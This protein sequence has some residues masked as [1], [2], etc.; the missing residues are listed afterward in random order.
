MCG[1]VGFTTRPGCPAPEREARYGARLRSMTASLRHRGPDAQ[2]AVLLDGAALGHARL[3]IV[4]LAVGAQPMIDPR[5][6]VTLIFNGEIFNYVEPRAELAPG[7]AFRTTSDT[8][9]VL[10]SYVSRGI[11]CVNDFIGQFAFAIF[12][13]RTR[14]LWLARDRVGI[15]PLH[16]TMTS[17]G[18]AFA[19]EAKAI[20]AGGWRE[21]AIDAVAL[22]QTLQLWSP[23]VP[24]TMFEGI[25][26]LAPGSVARFADGRLET[27]RYWDLDLGVEPRADLSEDEAEAELGELLESA[28]R[29]RLRADVP[30]AAY[31]SGGLDSSLL[32]AI[33]Q[34][35]LG[36]TLSTYSVAFADRSFDERGYQQEV[37]RALATDH[38][39]VQIT[40]RAIGELLPD[41]VFHAEQVLVRSAPAPLYALSGL[42]N[43]HRT[44]VVLTGEGSDEIFWGYDLFGEARVRQ[45]WSRQPKSARRPTLLRRL[46]PYLPLSE[47]GDRMLMAHSVEGRFP[48]LD[49]RLIE[50]AATLPEGLKL[51]GLKEKWILKRYA[52]RWVPER[53]LRRRKFPYRAPI[54]SA[55]TGRQAPR[56]ANALMSRDAIRER[57]IFD[58]DKIARLVAKLSAQSSS[59]SET[60]SQ[61]IM[62]VATTQLLAEQFL[63]PAAVAQADI[64]AVD[65]AAA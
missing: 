59:P 60:D 42:V 64:D 28:V 47:Q 15:L 50:F 53:V 2:R 21:P 32:S 9:V 33:A 51:R 35:Q 45:F 49:H 29:L 13:P 34:S 8:E 6:G 16:Y 26:Q 54:A 52:A 4:D 46:Y 23:V 19:S 40:S 10:A 41:V 17:E 1:I 39:S 62:A 5:S 44:K 7:Y 31:L 48:F 12:D 37:A 38:R 43:E 61:A 18:L 56:W 11:D 3:A 30:V 55:L 25:S 58:D 22:K 63:A 27:R 14:A 36:G 65:L 57:G 24:R 20:F